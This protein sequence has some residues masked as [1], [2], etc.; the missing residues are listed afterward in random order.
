MVV[1]LLAHIFIFIVLLAVGHG[2]PS[3]YQVPAEDFI[4]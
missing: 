1:L 2:N 4:T 3:M